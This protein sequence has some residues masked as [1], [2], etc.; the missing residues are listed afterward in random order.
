VDKDIRCR[1]LEYLVDLVQSGW[2]FEKI[3]ER[4]E[5][6]KFLQQGY[7]KETTEAMAQ[8][9]DEKINQEKHKIN[10]DISSNDFALIDCIVR[11]AMKMSQS[12][13]YQSLIMDITAVH[14]NGCKLDL[15][16][17]FSADD[18]N[19]THDVF[20]IC[21]HIDRDTGKLKN[22]FIPRYADQTL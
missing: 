2:T 21:R 18:F 13:D 5:E 6:G 16:G 1:A 7:D 17:L 4:I 14:A 20:G 11:K 22:C 8:I 15:I 12:V 10:W 9:C 19:F 3:R